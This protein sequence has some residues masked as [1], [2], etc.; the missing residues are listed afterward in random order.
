MRREA[1]GIK[2]IYI[3]DDDDDTVSVDA[4]ELSLPGVLKVMAALKADEGDAHSTSTTEALDEDGYPID[5][6]SLGDN[7]SDGSTILHYLDRHQCNEKKNLAEESIAELT[8]D[9]L[10]EDSREDSTEIKLLLGDD[11][12][13]E[14]D[15][16]DG[17]DSL[18]FSKTTSIADILANVGSR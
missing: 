6:Y 15:E 8:E 18:A 11:D 17:D 4:E 5:N 3:N 14:E 12:T 13:E 10:E 9:G 7:N 2:E 16:D 1:V